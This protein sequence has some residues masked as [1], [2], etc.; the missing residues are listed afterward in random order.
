VLVELAADP[1]VQGWARTCGS[2][3]GQC[4]QQLEP[5]GYRSVAT[6]FGLRDLLDTAFES[7]G[8]LELHGELRC[9]DRVWTRP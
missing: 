7:H 2:A 6:H 5:H 1:K 8:L 4:C 9:G 3:P